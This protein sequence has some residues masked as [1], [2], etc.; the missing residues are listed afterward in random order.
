MQNRKIPLKTQI[1]KPANYPSS[2][3]TTTTTT[4]Y[5]QQQ[6]QQQQPVLIE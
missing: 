2:Q 1:L 6:Q 3:M 4:T 5:T